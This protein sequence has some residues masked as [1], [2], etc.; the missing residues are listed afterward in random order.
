MYTVETCLCNTYV[1]LK[2]CKNKS[3]VCM[4]YQPVSLTSAVCNL[5]EYIVVSQIMK[6][7]IHPT[8]YKMISLASG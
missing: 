2:R 8:L 3:Y 4:N 5:M 1:F 7:S 6:H